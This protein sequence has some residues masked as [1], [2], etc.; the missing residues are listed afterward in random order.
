MNH[1]KSTL[2]NFLAVLLAAS[3]AGAVPHADAK[4]NYATE[5]EMIEHAE[6]IAIVDISLQLPPDCPRHGSSDPQGQVAEGDQAL[7]GRVV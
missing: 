4:A 6:V 5:D 7:R 3:L 2:R 1:K